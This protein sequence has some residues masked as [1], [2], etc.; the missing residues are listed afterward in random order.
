MGRSSF[1]PPSQADEYGNGVEATVNS[2]R[3]PALLKTRPLGQPFL[4]QC[5][6]L[7]V[8]ARCCDEEA[9]RLQRQGHLNSYVTLQGQEAAQIASVLAMRRRDQL[10]P[11]YRGR[12]VGIARF[13]VLGYLAWWLHARGWLG[14]RWPSYAPGP[15]CSEEVAHLL[16]AAGW[17][18]G[19]QLAGTSDV[20]LAYFETV[21]DPAEAV[22]FAGV[23]H[24]P[25]I[26][27]CL[28]S[29]SGDQ[30]DA[31]LRL[32]RAE[33]CGLAAAR[34]D[35]NDPVAIHKAT[36]AAATRARRGL[37]GTLIQA[38]C[39]DVLSIPHQGLRDQPLDELQRPDPIL[40][41]RKRLT[42]LYGT[43]QDF[44]NEVGEMASAAAA[45]LRFHLTTRLV[46]ASAMFEQVYAEPPGDVLVE[47]AQVRVGEMAHA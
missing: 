29:D 14:R 39:P 40:T 20:A 18:H 33:S 27:F 46:R 8:L 3:R 41:L 5:Y 30:L 36:S 1:F 32:G 2:R 12:G 15:I 23:F 7:M 9:S 37:G 42:A 43:T 19:A 47:W 38:D 34:V 35:G 13:D 45:E 6:Q 22:R 21:V 31:S 44:F 16:H 24:A 17:A 28:S 11:S 26:F 10:F 4:L 25:V